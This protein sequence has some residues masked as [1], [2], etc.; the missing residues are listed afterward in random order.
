MDLD[1]LIADQAKDDH[2]KSWSNG[3]TVSLDQ[4][5]ETDT[6]P[7]DPHY[8]EWADPTALEALGSDPTGEAVTG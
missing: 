4:K 6:E 5:W 2:Y 3:K 8:D 1:E 7:W